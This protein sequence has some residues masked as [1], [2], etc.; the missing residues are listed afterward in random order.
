L[1]LP[2][3]GGVGSDGSAYLD[4]GRVELRAADHVALSAAV[5]TRIERLLVRLST[6]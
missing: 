4:G 6:C 1:R 2:T 5:N 3:R